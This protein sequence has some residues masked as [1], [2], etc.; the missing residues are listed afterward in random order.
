MKNLYR[1][2]RLDDVSEDVPSKTILRLNAC[3]FEQCDYLFYGKANR[4]WKQLIDLNQSTGA[5]SVKNVLDREYLVHSRLC[6]Q[7]DCILHFNIYDRQNQRLEIVEMRVMDVNDNTPVFEKNQYEIQISENVPI[8]HTVWLPKARDPDSGENSRLTYYLFDWDDE[9]IGICNT[10]SYSN[11]FQILIGDDELKIRGKL[12]Y[13]TR[14]NY[15]LTLVASDNGNPRRSSSTKLIIK[16]LDENDNRPICKPA[17]HNISIPEDLEIYSTI[18]RVFATDADSPRFATLKYEISVVAPE[19]GNQLFSIDPDNGTVY[20]TGK[21]DHKKCSH[22]KIFVAVFDDEYS[23]PTICI[24]FVEVTDVYDSPPEYSISIYEP[25]LSIN[26]RQ[27]ISIREDCLKGHLVAVIDLNRKGNAFP[28]TNYTVSWNCD[29]LKVTYHDEVRR[30]VITV[31]RLDREEKS[32]HDCSLTITDPSPYRLRT[33][34]E[35]FVEVTDVNDNAPEAFSTVAVLNATDAEYEGQNGELVFSLIVGNSTEFAVDPNGKL[36]TLRDFDKENGDECFQFAIKIEDKGNPPL[37][38]QKHAEV[39]ILDVNDNMPTFKSNIFVFSVKEDIQ[40]GEVI[41]VI[42]AE[43][44][45][46]FSNGQVDIYACPQ[47]DKTFDH[48]TFPFSIAY[49]GIIRTNS[50]LN[51]EERTQYNL[52]VCIKDLGF[53]PRH[54][55]P[56]QIVINIKNINDH[57]PRFMSFKPTFYFNRDLKQQTPLYVTVNDR[58]G[59]D[60]QIR[61]SIVSFPQFQFSVTPFM[62]LGTGQQF[63]IEIKNLIR[64]L[65]FTQS[66][67]TQLM[68][69]LMKMAMKIVYQVLMLFFSWEQMILRIQM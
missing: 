13:E 35:M 37:S 16:I 32:L 17:I 69:P 55:K 36:K 49:D 54:G 14:T 42:E 40:I 58:D 8:G 15:N 18:G 43:D 1:V 48:E 50:Y 53:P 24:L 4:S 44:K 20:L 21:L 31:N 12:D 64:R 34:V 9:C 52:S 41:G 11:L 25:E 62:N 65:K 56:A 2:L 7:E 33:I 46:S 23:A 45:D 19:E 22:F 5:L 63:K 47:K 61:A 29:A 67:W 57:C 30:H 38:V 27:T 68:A 6:N 3:E 51:Y 28:I 39:C 60:V 66:A 59:D 10:F 26:G